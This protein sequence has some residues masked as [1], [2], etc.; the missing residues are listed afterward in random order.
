MLPLSTHTRENN[1][2][3]LHILCLK[4]HLCVYRLYMEMLCD[5]TFIYLLDH[6]MYTLP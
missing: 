2:V 5:M 3:R 1:P 6:F 4:L